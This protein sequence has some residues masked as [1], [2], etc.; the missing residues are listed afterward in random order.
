MSHYIERMSIMA[1]QQKKKTREQKIA[2]GE[3]P[4]KPALVVKPKGPAPTSYEPNLG[5]MKRRASI[6]IATARNQEQAIRD[7]AAQKAAAEQR[8]KLDSYLDFVAG[9]PGEYHIDGFTADGVQVCE[10]FNIELFQPKN[11]SSG[12]T[13]PVIVGHKGVHTKHCDLLKEKEDIHLLDGWRGEIQVVMLD[14]LRENL[15]SLIER[16]KT[17]WSEQRKDLRLATVNGKHVTS[18]NYRQVILP[19]S[20]FTP[21]TVGRFSFGD[22]QLHC[23]VIQEMVEG[24]MIIRVLEIQD[25]HT[26]ALQGLEPGLWIETASLENGLAHEVHNHAHVLRLFILDKLAKKRKPQAA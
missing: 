10:V 15:S 13:Y 1:K 21:E 24:K 12:H 22:G 25:G 19:L 16:Q 18:Q 5:R 20:R 2:E 6:E 7:A 23:H 4:A 11:G 3:K 14:F 26:L 9:I 8:Y 17:I